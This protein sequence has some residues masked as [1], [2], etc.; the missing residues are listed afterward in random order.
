MT[1]ADPAEE[2]AGREEARKMFSRIVSGGIVPP[3]SGWSVSMILFLSTIFFSRNL[4]NPPFLKTLDNKKLGD[5]NLDI[6]ENEQWSNA[7][8]VVVMAAFYNSS[9]Y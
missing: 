3:R 9:Y 4:S 7:I 5:L 6:C 2:P 8:V 1:M